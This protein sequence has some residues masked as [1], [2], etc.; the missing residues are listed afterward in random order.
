MRNNLLKRALSV[1]LS[2]VLVA[3]YLPVSQ[4]QAATVQQP[5]NIIEGS[6]K[7]DAH[8]IVWEKFFGPDVM[9]TEFAG[10]VWTDKSVFAE[11]TDLLPGIALNDSN[12]FLVALSALASN[13]S[14]TGHTTSPTD[15]MLVLDLSESMV[16]K[17]YDVGYICSGD[18][19]HL[20]TGIDI[21]LMEAMV[22]ATNDTIAA[23]MKQNSNNRVGVVLYSGNAADS[24]IVVLPLG[25]YTG[26]NGAYLSLDV[27]YTTSTLY[28]YDSNTRWWASAGQSAPYV[29]SASA[30]SVSVADNLKTEEGA[31]VAD[32]SKTVEGGTYF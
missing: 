29:D 15:T 24:A 20:A 31:A 3:S 9:H 8:S 5:L 32:L 12:N 14:I 7:A 17:I 4:V 23:L 13:V 6:K 10:A 1:L 21:S 27:Q 11:E 19:Y 18:R 30:V 2:L 28:T 16:D 25:R 22:K 26:V